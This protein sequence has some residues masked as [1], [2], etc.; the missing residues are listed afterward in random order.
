MVGVGRSTRVGGRA[1]RWRG[2]R[3]NQGGTVQLNWSVSFTRGQGRYRREE[4]ENGSP[5]SSVHARWRVAEVQ[6]G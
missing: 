5:D 2:L 6:Q 3:P 4:L 1:R